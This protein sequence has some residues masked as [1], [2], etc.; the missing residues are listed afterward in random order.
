MDLIVP[1]N[2]GQGLGEES[3]QVP[4]FR[5]YLEEDHTRRKVGTVSFNVEG[6]GQVGRDEDWSRGDTSLQPSE[7]GTLSFSPVPT[8]IVSDQVEERVGV[9]REVPDELSVE[10][11]EPEEGLHFLLICQS[12]PLS[13]ASDLD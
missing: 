7:C 9:F 6:F 11:G 2:R 5:R 3:D 13:N 1:L 4:L 8:G 12:R 10:V